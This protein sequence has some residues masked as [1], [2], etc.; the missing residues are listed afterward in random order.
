MP[1]YVIA[2]TET[3]KLLKI[4]EKKNS[5]S[6]QRKTMHYTGKQ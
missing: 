3:E 6:N 1:T 5:E 2:E 4:K